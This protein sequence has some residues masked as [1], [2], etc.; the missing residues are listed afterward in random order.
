MCL[1]W[2]SVYYMNGSPTICYIWMCLVLDFWCLTPLS[3]IFQLY[4][5]DQ[6]YWRRKPEYPEK[7]IGLPQV[8]SFFTQCCTPRHE[9]DSN[10]QFSLWRIGFFFHWKQ[11]CYVYIIVMWWIY[12][13]RYI[14]HH[15]S[16]WL[17]IQQASLHMILRCI[18]GFTSI[19][20]IIF[21]L[22]Y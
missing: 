7:T 18:C 17:I 10:S 13:R 1:F 8:T 11:I 2:I 3:T 20:K 19:L 9:R 14:S 12:I 15:I 5:G 6:F 4:P 22:N 16:C 21:I